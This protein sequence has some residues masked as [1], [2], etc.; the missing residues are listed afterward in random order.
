[1]WRCRLGQQK[2]KLIKY[3]FV[4][5]LLQEFFRECDDIAVIGVDDFITFNVARIVEI[6]GAWADLKRLAVENVTPPAFFNNDKR[7]VVC[8][9]QW[10]SFRIVVMELVYDVNGEFGFLG[11][12]DTECVIELGDGIVQS[13]LLTICEL[14]K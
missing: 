6:D 10:G 2:G 1:M 7:V 3:A 14:V 5:I 4:N 11:Q 8:S 12:R 13:Y 9:E